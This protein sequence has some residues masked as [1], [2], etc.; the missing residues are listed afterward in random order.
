MIFVRDKGQMCN[1]MLQYGHMY[2]WGREHGR[3]TVSMR[4]AYKYQYFNIC[5]TKYHWFATYL[6]AKWGAGLG[7]IPR[8]TFPFEKGLDTSKQEAELMQHRMCI[9][10]GWRV[11]FPELFRKYK[12]EIIELFQFKTYISKTVKER[13]AER[14]GGKT[15]RL[16]VH[17]RRGDYKTWNNGKY[18]FNDIVYASFITRFMRINHDRKV[19]VYISTNDPGVNEA[20]FRKLCD[21]NNIFI[22]KGNPAEDLCMLSECDYII[23]PP[24]TFSLVGCMYRDIPIHW[25]MTS[26][27]EALTT[28]GFK[29]F[30][31]LFTQIL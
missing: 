12:K 17:I 10:E 26:D 3:T 16:G 1:N 11:E 21:D 5:N 14:D 27:P 15:M 9:A 4:F 7:L 28:D 22:L 18:F 8:V 24:S 2:A 19:S 20:T 29:S 30:E 31:E 6:F 13:M 25:M 23:G